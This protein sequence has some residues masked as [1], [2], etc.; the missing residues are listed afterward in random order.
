LICVFFFFFQDASD[1]IA[2]AESERVAHV[3]EP[4]P[5]A[6]VLTES[7][8]RVEVGAAAP[9]PEGED[10]EPVVEVLTGEHKVTSFYS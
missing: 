1:V 5:D 9:E 8:A 2:A 4:E 7:E 10:Q 3:L 6:D